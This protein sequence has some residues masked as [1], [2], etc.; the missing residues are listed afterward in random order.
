MDDNG[1]GGCCLNKIWAWRLLIILGNENLIL[2]QGIKKN[3]EN[4]ESG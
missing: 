4:E 1:G 3:G 2:S